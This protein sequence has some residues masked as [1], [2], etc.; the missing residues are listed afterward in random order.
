VSKALRKCAK[1]ADRALPK[2][3]GYINIGFFSTCVLRA[4]SPHFEGVLEIVEGLEKR[5]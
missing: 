5:R 4:F 3:G 1:K 2:C